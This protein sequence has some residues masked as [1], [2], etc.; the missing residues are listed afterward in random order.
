MAATI[1][2]PL[3]GGTAICAARNLRVTRSDCNLLEDIN[4]EAHAGEVLTLLGPNGAGKSTLLAALSGE[5]TPSAGEVDFCG[6][7]IADWSLKD[8][9]RRR[10][11]LLQE[12]KLMF[13]FS[14]GE[15]VEMGRAPWQR[16]PLDHDDEAAIAEAM[17]VAEV[18]HLADRRVPSL[19]GGER[20]RVSFARVLATRAQ[21][22]MLD[23]PTAALDL[24]HQEAVL[25]TARALAAQGSAVITVL[26][27]LNLAA[28]YSDRIALLKKGRLQAIGTPRTVLTSQTVSEVY[29]TPVEVIAHPRTGEPLVLPLRSLA[30]VCEFHEVV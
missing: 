20:A 4:L 19:S 25:Q 13:P 3:P 2:I 29:D 5:L 6:Y 7:P 16:T 23:E 30:P 26:H 8:L 12:H 18:T 24:K 28:A 22:V 21:V 17:E 11:V 1:P 14:A 10:S 9:A 15:V 27:D